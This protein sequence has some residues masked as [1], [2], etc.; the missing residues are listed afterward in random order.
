VKAAQA[1][2]AA[3][4]VAGPPAPAADAGT[5]RDFDAVVLDEADHWTAEAPEGSRVLALAPEAIGEDLRSRNTSRI[6]V[7]LAAPGTVEALGQLAL[8]GV[9]DEAWACIARSG[10]DELLHVGRLKPVCFPVDPE[11]VASSFERNE[12]GATRVLAVASNVD[13]VLA[14]RKALSDRGAS[15]SVAWSAKQAL[16]LIP[17]LRPQIA[18]VELAVTLREGAE[19]V[20]LLA[21]AERAP[22]FVFLPG[23]ADASRAFGV[24]LGLPANADLL[25]PRRRWLARILRGDGGA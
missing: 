21:R 5:A 10:R 15:V 17:M 3:A 18:I 24:Q 7:N 25:T 22:T 23:Q 20:V 16:D 4:S 19:A 8:T 6:I 13:T 1:T 11:A 14:L 9:H 12:L 2:A